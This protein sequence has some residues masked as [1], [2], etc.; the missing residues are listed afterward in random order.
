MLCESNASAAATRTFQFVMLY[1]LSHC[2][3]CVYFGSFE[4]LGADNFKSFWPKQ[5]SMGLTTL[6]CFLGPVAAAN[7]RYSR[8]IF[9]LRCETQ[10]TASSVCC[11]DVM[12]DDLWSD[13][14]SL[15]KSS[16]EF[17]IQS[18]SVFIWCQACE[19]RQSTRKGQISIYLISHFFG[20]P[21]INVVLREL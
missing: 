18:S 1:C 2:W 17:G 11:D 8:S 14:V 16:G 21:L 15:L 12:T 4:D 6:C 10:E 7:P 20:L 19:S 9:T 13:L 5:L 3:H